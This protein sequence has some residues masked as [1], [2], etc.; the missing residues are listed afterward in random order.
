MTYILEKRSGPDRSHRE[1]LAAENDLA[2]LER[3]FRH[4]TILVHPGQTLCI[5]KAESGE[6]LKSHDRS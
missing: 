6:V 4:L 3:T 1:V 2:L 5:V